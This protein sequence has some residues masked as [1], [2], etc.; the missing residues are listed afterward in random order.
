MIK[1]IAYKLLFLYRSF[2]AG[3][4]TFIT[5]KTGC[6]DDWTKEETYRGNVRNLKI[7]DRNTLLMVLYDIHISKYQKVMNNLSEAFKLCLQGDTVSKLFSME[8]GDDLD[9]PEFSLK[10][11]GGRK[12]ALCKRVKHWIVPENLETAREYVR[13]YEESKN[14]SP[15]FECGV[16]AVKYYLNERKPKDARKLLETMIPI[17]HNL[18]PTS[19]LRYYFP[20]VIDCSSDDFPWRNAIQVILDNA[21]HL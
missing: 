19:S 11:I 4:R 12:L 17:L 1:P 5:L 21:R 6:P 14:D 8:E 20:A 16:L 13:A 9:D 2:E 10:E 3:K 18:P 7:F 15:G